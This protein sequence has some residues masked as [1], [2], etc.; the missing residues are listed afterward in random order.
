MLPGLQGKKNNII[1][2]NLLIN[3]SVF[4]IVSL[5]YLRD[6]FFRYAKNASAKQ[7]NL[8]NAEWTKILIDL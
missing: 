6:L 1:N 4:G 7:D 5:L 3:I 8:F 2:F